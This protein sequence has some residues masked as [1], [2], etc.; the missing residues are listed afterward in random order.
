MPTFKGTITSVSPEQ[1]GTSK[2]GRAWSKIDAVLTYDNSKP[3]YPKA[4]VFSVMNDN[5]SRFDLQVGAEY[6]LEID[7]SVREYQGRF[8]QSASAWK[9]TR[10]SQPEPPQPSAPPAADSEFPF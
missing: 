4:V 1:S 6:E 5:I 2:A 8:Y 10:M 7:F 9:A 3:E